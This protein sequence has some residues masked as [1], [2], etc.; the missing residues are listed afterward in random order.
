MDDLPANGDRRRRPGRTGC[1]LF[2]TQCITDR[3]AQATRLAKRMS[4]TEM[5]RL[6]V[7]GSDLP[8]LKHSGRAPRMEPTV[9]SLASLSRERGGLGRSTRGSPISARMC[10][11]AGRVL[12][13]SMPGLASRRPLWWRDCSRPSWV[14]TKSGRSSRWL[15]FARWRGVICPRS[16]SVNAHTNGNLD[17]LRHPW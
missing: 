17:K 16:D 4:P 12:S 2:P 8:H 15:I 7:Y 13:S 11:H 10:S 1:G 3:R 5:I 14:E 6:S 9:A